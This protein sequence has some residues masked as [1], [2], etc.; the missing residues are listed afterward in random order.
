MANLGGLGAREGAPVTYNWILPNLLYPLLSWLLLVA[1]LLGPKV[2]P[3]AAAWWILAPVAAVLIGQTLVSEAGL[4]PSGGEEVFGE[5]IPA[6]AFGLAAVW[7]RAPFLARSHRVLAFLCLAPTLAL[8]SSAA[9]AIRQDWTG[10]G[11]LLLMQGM[12]FLAF[13]AGVLALGLFLARLICR[14]SHRPAG[15]AL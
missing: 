15:L 2:N 6:L 1:L 9:F 11:G 10:D 5:A 12:V 14:R 7:L 4:L 8:A 13:G 3:R